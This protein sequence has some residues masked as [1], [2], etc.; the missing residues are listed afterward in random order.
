MT[1]NNGGEDDDS[2][3]RARLDKLAGALKAQRPEPSAPSNASGPAAS[4][5]TMG[6]GMAMAM[7]AGGE[8]VAAI[9]VGAAIGLGLDWALHTRPAFT[10]AF[11][12]IGVAAGVWNVIRATSPKG[13]PP[14][15]NS[16]L[17]DAKAGDKDVPRGAPSW[18]DEDED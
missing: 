15:R 17:S 16:S 1:H 12:L 4:P 14:D 11:F 9:L 7:R 10:I 13:A 5:E 3:L 2:A 6:S 8:F 18:G